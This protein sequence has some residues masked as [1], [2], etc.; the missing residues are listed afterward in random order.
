MA[1]TRY[2]LRDKEFDLYL[3]SVFTTHDGQGEGYRLVESPEFGTTTF[4]TK[5][6]AEAY[7]KLLAKP[8]DWEVVPC[9][10]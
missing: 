2:A 3:G 6:K 7:R 1:V 10:N 4:D 8:W 5:E 9:T